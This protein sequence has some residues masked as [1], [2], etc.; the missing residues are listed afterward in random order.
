M[1]AV[2]PPPS[3]RAMSQADPAPD[4]DP[5]KPAA[6]RV[7][8]LWLF[9][10]RWLLAPMYVGLVVG[11]AGLIVVFGQEVVHETG[12]LFA[13]MAPREAIVVAL[14]LVDLSLAANLMLIVIFAGYENFVAPIEPADGVQRPDWMGAV[15]FAGLK[16]KLVASIVA[17]S[18]VALLRVFVQL[19]EGDQS[20]DNR[21]L[22]WLVGLHA[23]FLVSGVALALMDLITATAK[24]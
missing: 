24:R 6:E 22:G 8:E 9:R 3:L 12:E 4:A 18:A 17:I 1:A 13:G 15:D 5:R 2:G 14:S 19:A 21:T 20:L 10:S 7:L 16:L 11:M 23:V